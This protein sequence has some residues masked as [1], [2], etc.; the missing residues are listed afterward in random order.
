MTATELGGIFLSSEF[1]QDLEQLSSCLA[2]IKQERPIVY[3]LAKQLWKGS[4]K[5]QLEAKRKDLVINGRRI[6]FKF[7][8][9]C[10]MER[11]AFQLG[12]CGDMSLEEMRKAS[13]A[14]GKSIGWNN[15]LLI[16]DDICVKKADIFVWIICSR[17]L[18]QLAPDALNR[19]CW[20]KAQ[21]KWNMEHP[22]GSDRKFLTVADKFFDK[23]P[24]PY[25]VLEKKIVT[26]GDFHSTYYFRIY[27]FTLD[28]HN[29][30]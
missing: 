23:I 2:S 11:L 27:D 26:E 7:E 10:G 8:Y 16:Y 1:K 19:I 25:R 9:D 5:F 18:S 24:R 3:C 17:D 12:K 13:R 15:M 20:S 30:L 6:E 22:Y 28:N 21:I 14:E 29:A 4:H